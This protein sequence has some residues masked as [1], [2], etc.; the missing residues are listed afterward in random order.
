MVE[1]V[2]VREVVGEGCMVRGDAGS[3][4]DGARTS[5]CGICLV[6]GNGEVMDGAGGTMGGSLHPIR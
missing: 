2:C 4:K 6:V 3:A 5:L 1:G